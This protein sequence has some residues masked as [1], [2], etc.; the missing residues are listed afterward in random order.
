MADSLRRQFRY[1]EADPLFRKAA[2]LREKATA[3]DA[4]TH[5]YLRHLGWCLF[6]FGHH[7]PARSF[8]Q[9]A[10]NGLKELLGNEHPS[11]LLAMNDLAVDE[12]DS[13]VS[14]AL[15]RATYEAELSVL[16]IDHPNTLSTMHNLAIGLHN[17]GKHTEAHSLYGIVIP[18]RSEVLG[19]NS[20]L[21]FDSVSG[22][23]SCLDSLG[24]FQAA[25]GKHLEAIRGQRQTAG[26]HPHTFSALHKYALFLER[27][28]RCVEAEKLYQEALEGRQDILGNKHIDTLQTLKCKADC[29]R[30]QGQL[31]LAEQLYRDVMQRFLDVFGPTHKST[32]AVMEDLAAC[33][34]E[35]GHREAATKLYEDALDLQQRRQ[36]LHPDTLTSINNLA[37]RLKNEG[38]LAKAEELYQSTVAGR[39]EAFGSDHADTVHALR[40]MAVFFWNEENTEDF[41]T[42]VQEVKQLTPQVPEVYKQPRTRSTQKEGSYAEA[43]ALY[44]DLVKLRKQTLGQHEDT[45]SALNGLS[46]CLEDQGNLSKAE[47]LYG[48]VVAGRRKVLVPDDANTM[49]AV[50][51]LAIFYWNQD[52]FSEAEDPFRELLAWHQKASGAQHQDTLNTMDSLAFCLEVGGNNAEAQ[53]LRGQMNAIK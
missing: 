14:E 10:V 29:L 27:K 39:R 21:V 23:A 44:R 2:E 4:R 40:N 52:R 33:L 47:E 51:N 32:S 13:I 43:E 26:H 30:K 42:Y 50:R 7:D 3:K 9:D 1:E 8:D 36:P 16:G 28:G 15:L 41:K 49:N 24:G 46:S 53:A 35:M 25:E 12:E 11:T 48:G 19:P 20:S 22:L 31:D 18:W 5:D 34:E 37:I 38:K 45:I 6:D 17:L